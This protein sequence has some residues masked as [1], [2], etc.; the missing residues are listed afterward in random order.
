MKNNGLAQSESSLFKPFSMPLGQYTLLD[1][2]SVDE[3]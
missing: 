1:A 3:E 2:F